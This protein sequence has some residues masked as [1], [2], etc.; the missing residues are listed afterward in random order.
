M[1][2]IETKGKFTM[3]ALSTYSTVDGNRELPLIQPSMPDPVD[4]CRLSS[5]VYTWKLG[6]PSSSPIDFY[7]TVTMFLSMSLVRERRE[8]GFS[9]D[10]SLKEFTRKSRVYTCPFSLAGFSWVL[11]T[12]D[13]NRHPYS[14]QHLPCP[15]AS[16]LQEKQNAKYL[17]RPVCGQ[18]PQTISV[19]PTT[20]LLGG[21][22]S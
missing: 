11:E 17:R 6:V 5:N 19:I 2:N 10:L 9:K 21:A 22:R 14:R 7:C 1:S 3:R 8:Q 16:T 13:A 18:K 4:I 15:P 12:W 20:K